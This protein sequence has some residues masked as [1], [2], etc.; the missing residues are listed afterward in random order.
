MG[1]CYEFG[2]SVP[3]GVRCACGGV[4][5]VV[6]TLFAGVEDSQG[7]MLG[8]SS[9]R[10]GVDIPGLHQRFCRSEGM[11]KYGWRACISFEGYPPRPSG[12]DL[13]FR[14]VAEGCGLWASLIRAVRNG[15]KR[16][17]SKG[18]ANSMGMTLVVGITGLGSHTN[19]AV[20]GA[21]ARDKKRVPVLM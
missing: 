14:S 7:T 13:V 5:G 4:C 15:Q 12:T 9:V 8:V 21:W 10:G 2:S 11:S 20:G 16:R 1:V 19:M 17:I 6:A 18:T 3:R